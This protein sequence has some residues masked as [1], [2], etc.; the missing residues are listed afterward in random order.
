MTRRIDGQ[1]RAGNDDGISKTHVLG[2]N[3]DCLHITFRYLNLLDLCAVADV[4]ARFRE[5]AEPYFAKTEHKDINL[6]R[7]YDEDGM[8]GICKVLR[9]TG[10]LAESIKVQSS[11]TDQSEKFENGIVELLS[12]HCSDRTRILL[13]LF[14]VE[15]Y[16]IEM[17]PSLIILQM[18]TTDSIRDEINDESE[19]FIQDFPR[20]LN[21]SA[22][23]GLEELSLN[24]AHELLD[25][26][27]F[28]KALENNPQLKKIELIYCRF[29]DDSILPLIAAHVPQIE[30]LRFNPAG[31]GI[32]FGINT[33]CLSRLNNLKTLIISCNGQPISST[34]NEM[35]AAN[36]QLEHLKIEEPYISEI[37]VFFDGISELKTLKSLKLFGINYGMNF[38]H[39][40]QIGENLVELTELQLSNSIELNADN[41]LQLIRINKKLQ[42]FYYRKNPSDNIYFDGNMQMEMMKIARERRKKIHL[43]IS[44]RKFSNEMFM[45]MDILNCH[46]P[47]LLHSGMG[48]IFSI[49]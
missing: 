13:K 32:S 9:N 20:M 7:I 17:L 44:E 3:N 34:I 6:N 22:L 18:R 28:E 45:L 19:Q 15:D 36:I 10:S 2:L 48:L 49:K 1:W 16:R 25:N 4:C 12:R 35:A 30:S 39:A 23:K 37:D 46:E 27:D 43:K 47:F 21:F 33:M 24:V 26:E 8:L 5:N 14:S 11:L 42:H 31:E 41:L 38:R 40:I 29:I